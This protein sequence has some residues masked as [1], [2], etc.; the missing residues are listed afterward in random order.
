MSRGEDVGQM[1][2]E[3]SKLKVDSSLQIPKT[4]LPHRSYIYPG[5][6]SLSNY[7]LQFIVLQKY[8]MV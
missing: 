5:Q 4:N 8:M 2:K 6:P 1:K 3:A 7:R